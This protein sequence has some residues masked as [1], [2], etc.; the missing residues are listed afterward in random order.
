MAHMRRGPAASIDKIHRH[1][2]KFFICD[3]VAVEILNIHKILQC[4]QQDVTCCC[5]Q[6]PELLT[7]THPS[8]CH[9]VIYH[10]YCQIWNKRFFQSK[11]KHNKTPSLHCQLHSLPVHYCACRMCAA[12]F[13][14]NVGNNSSDRLFGSEYVRYITLYTLIQHKR[15]MYIFLCK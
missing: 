15:K 5:L 14:I 2:Q 8:V 10:T 7:H 9:V 1:A 11:I 3:A 4:A 12:L 13:K 6:H